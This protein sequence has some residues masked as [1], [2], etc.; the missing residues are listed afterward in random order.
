MRTQ[1]DEAVGQIASLSGHPNDESVR[2]SAQS[3]I[4]DLT[5]TPVAGIERGKSHNEVLAVPRDRPWIRL[6]MP[7]DE[8]LFKAY[9][10]VLYTIEMRE[11]R[12][13]ENLKSR[14]TVTGIEVDWRIPSDSVQNGDYVLQL[15][16]RKDG[17]ASEHLSV[18]S[19]RVVRK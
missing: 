1:R 10:A 2:G 3:G 9:E 8:D 11:V 15:N 5:F 16:G 13:G 12:R 17:Q 6:E 18:Y 19:F 7:I 14:S 4:P